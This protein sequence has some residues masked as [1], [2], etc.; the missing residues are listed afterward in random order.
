MYIYLR[1]EV[2]KISMKDLKYE[3]SQEVKQDIKDK[4]SMEEEEDGD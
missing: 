1:I 2:S 3:E 4:I